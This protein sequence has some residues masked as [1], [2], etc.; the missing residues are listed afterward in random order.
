MVQGKIVIKRHKT[1]LTCV[2]CDSS[3]F[4]DRVALTRHGFTRGKLKFSFANGAYF[5]LFKEPLPEG[6]YDY[7]INGDMRILGFTWG[8]IAKEQ[9]DEKGIMSELN[10][11]GTLKGRFAHEAISSGYRKDD[12][13]TWK[14]LADLLRRTPSMSAESAGEALGESRTQIETRCKS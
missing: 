12:K 1:G 2:R 9:F 8:E 11:D 6:V 14:I 10:H 4:A 7:Q 3:F 5:R 13:S